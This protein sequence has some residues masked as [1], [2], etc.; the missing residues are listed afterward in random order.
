MITWLPSINQ[1]TFIC[2]SKQPP[3]GNSRV[4]GSYTGRLGVGGTEEVGPHGQVYRLN[5]TGMAHSRPLPVQTKPC[6]MQ[7]TPSQGF[8]GLLNPYEG[9][10]ASP[11]PKSPEAGDKDCHR[12]AVTA[13][14][15]GR[16]WRPVVGPHTF[17]Q[18]SHTVVCSTPPDCSRPGQLPR[19]HSRK[20]NF[21]CNNGGVYHANAQPWQTHNLNANAFVLMIYC[22]PNNKA[23]SPVPSQ[24]PRSHTWPRKQWRSLNE[25]TYFALK[26]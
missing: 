7:P 5:H 4:S 25:V 9:R 17:T 12:M 21:A 16:G 3:F 18:L 6:H 26:W 11:L 14:Y 13:T 20:A 24:M 10:H 1:F 8:I 19:A 2:Q 22:R 15:K 23:F